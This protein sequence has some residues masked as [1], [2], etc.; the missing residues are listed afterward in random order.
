LLPEIHVHLLTAVPNAQVVECVPRSA[1]LLRA[2]PEI[3]DGALVVPAG[4]GF[5]LELD[6]DAVRRFT[7]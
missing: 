4:G 1:A 6:R 7:V 3:S 5:G 2:M